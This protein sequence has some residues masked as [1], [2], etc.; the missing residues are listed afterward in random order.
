MLL[1]PCSLALS[2]PLSPSLSLSVGNIP[3]QPK[4]GTGGLLKYRYS[5]VL[6]IH[7]PSST[8]PKL[9]SQVAPVLCYAVPW[10]MIIAIRV[11]PYTHWRHLTV[12]IV[13][14]KASPT[15]AVMTITTALAQSRSAEP[16]E[17]FASTD[18]ETHSS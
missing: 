11:E 1:L 15:S 10:P 9:A 8:L 18:P 4:G 2:P 5:T 16:D 12:V 3:A 13:L 7:T 14:Q 17:E 6:Y